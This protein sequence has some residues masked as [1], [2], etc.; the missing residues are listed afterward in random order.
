MAS[1]RETMYLRFF[2]LDTNDDSPFN[3][4]E[5]RKELTTIFSRYQSIAVAYSGG[6]DSAVLME[7]AHRYFGKKAYAVL[8]DSASLPRREYAAA[9][10]LASERSW[11]L[12]VVKTEEFHDPR[13]L[14]NP[15]NRCYFCKSALFDQMNY[16]ARDRQV[17]ALAYGE[18]AD[19]A[20]EV[21][22]GRQAA[23]EFEVI[24][25]LME[26]GYH[27]AE[28]RALAMEWGMSVAEKVASPC[29]SSRIQT[30]VSIQA[31]DLLKIEAGEQFLH[32]LGFKICRIRFDGL[33]AKVFVSAH[34]LSALF[35]SETQE[36]VIHYLREL[37]FEKVEI[38]SEPYRGA[39]LR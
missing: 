3:F 28:V 39:S 24:A 7:S 36:R 1:L 22:F 13:Y 5:M 10:E 20:K 9:I 21:R 30:G 18:N 34:E 11:N 17:E 37:G 23:L 19:D 26:A 29:L 33:R 25:P 16:F 27:K 15:A 6:V 35:V 4:I 14:E 8:A 31:G 12:S 32:Q 2:V 38:S